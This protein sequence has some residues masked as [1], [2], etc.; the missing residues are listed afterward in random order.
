MTPNNINGLSDTFAGHDGGNT[1]VLS[2]NDFMRC[3]SQSN[4]KVS[5]REVE[6]LVKELD[7][8]G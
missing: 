7:S 8:S 1:G 6:L 3:L 4:M 2:N 5:D